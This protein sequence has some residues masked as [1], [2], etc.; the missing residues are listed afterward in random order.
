[1]K[2][3][4][5]VFFTCIYAYAINPIMIPLKGVKVEHTYSNG[6]KKTIQSK[7]KTTKSV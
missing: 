5:L 7:D 6:K 3:L 4:I 1:M 2:K